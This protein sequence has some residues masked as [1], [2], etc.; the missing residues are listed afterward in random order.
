MTRVDRALG[1]PFDRTLYFVINKTLK[2]PHDPVTPHVLSIAGTATS[3]L[4][5]GSGTGDIYKI[6]AITRRDGMELK[7]LSIPRDFALEG[8]EWHCQIKLD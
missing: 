3:S 7:V 1:V 6:F 2:K 4:I 5:S 8:K